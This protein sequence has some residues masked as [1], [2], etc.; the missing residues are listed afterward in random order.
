M[1]QIKIYLI[2]LYIINDGINVFRMAASLVQRE[3]DLGI[4]PI[5]PLDLLL[6]VEEHPVEKNLSCHPCRILSIIMNQ[7]TVRREVESIKNVNLIF[8]NKIVVH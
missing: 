1:R 5:L 3:N 6:Q 2:Y 7:Y 8:S 4:L